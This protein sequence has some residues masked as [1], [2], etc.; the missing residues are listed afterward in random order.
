MSESSAT[1]GLPD[2]SRPSGSVILEVWAEL[3]NSEDSMISLSLTV[4][5][6]SEGTSI[7]TK[8][9]PGIGA[10]IRSDLA[11]SASARSFLRLV[12]LLK[13]VI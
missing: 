4:I 9:L 10:S 12:I 13:K 1:M 8:A 11:A 6:F 3:R 5:L 7:P 2:T